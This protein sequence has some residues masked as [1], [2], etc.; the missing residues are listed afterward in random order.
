MGTDRLLKLLLGAVLAMTLLAPAWAG[1]IN[2]VE[3][4]EGNP[5]LPATASPSSD[6]LELPLLPIEEAPAEETVPEP[7]PPVEEPAQESTAE[8]TA[9]P[10]ME[11]LE[12][13]VEIEA[14]PADAAMPI[15]DDTTVPVIEAPVEEEEEGPATAAE[16]PVEITLNAEVQP[17]LKQAGTL[18]YQGDAEGAAALYRE[19]IDMD[20]VESWLYSAAVA[21]YASA[22]RAAG[23]RDEAEHWFQEALTYNPDDPNLRLALGYTLA[24]NNKLD[25]ALTQFDLVEQRTQNTSVVALAKARAYAWNGDYENALQYYNNVADPGLQDDAALGRAYVLYW[26]GDTAAARAMLSTVGRDDEDTRKL[27]AMLGPQHTEHYYADTGEPSDGSFAVTHRNATINDNNTLTGT[28]ATL[29]IPMGPE[30]SRIFISHEDFDLDNDANPPTSP[31]TASGTNTRVGFTAKLDDKTSLTGYVGK[32]SI[33]NSI[34]QTIDH[35]DI[36]VRLAGH[37]DDWSYHAS[38][39]D[40][41]LYDTPV[42]AAIDDGRSNMEFGLGFQV[43]GEDTTLNLLYATTEYGAAKLN[44]YEV[45]LRKSSLYDCDGTLAYGIRYR[46]LQN[47]GDAAPGF[48]A[49][50]DYQLGELYL[51]W[52][53]SSEDEWHLDAGVGVGMQ[54]I[55]SGDWEST[56]RAAIGVRYDV[57]RDFL[58]RAGVSSSNLPGVADDGSGDFSRTEWYI[59]GEWVF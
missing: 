58:V 40:N 10:S 28:T 3:S 47:T 26:Q 27:R 29:T 32:V 34:P 42:L 19:V 44:G 24:E 22:L 14:A 55:D 56:M 57:S 43:F 8:E 33:D 35:T 39:E 12:E 45:D 16:A 6:D 20:N 54:S 46:T 7:A 18:L 52:V 37:S 15:A 53:D 49:P 11:S 48:F 25:R 38:Y 50:D 1:D 23:Q 30:G 21:G 51:N 2:Y 31:A 41:L 9:V 4:D 59:N 13:V 5:E 17:K 36:G